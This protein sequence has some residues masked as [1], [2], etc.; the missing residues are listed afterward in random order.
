MLKV[1]GRCWYAES[2]IFMTILLVSCS[3]LYLC[4]VWAGV[5]TPG[6]LEL[7]CFSRL[8]DTLFIQYVHMCMQA[9]AAANSQVQSREELEGALQQQDTL[10]RSLDQ[11]TEDASPE[12]GPELTALHA[13]MHSAFR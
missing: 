9:T 5:K 12:G 8:Y 3:Q 13:S 1:L 4:A 7:V 2:H 11:E 6:V 10:Y